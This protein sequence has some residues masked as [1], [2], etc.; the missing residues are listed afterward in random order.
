[1]LYAYLRQ[2]DRKS[3]SRI[4]G[5]LIDGLSIT[6]KDSEP[7]CC[8]NMS[9]PLLFPAGRYKENPISTQAGGLN[10]WYW[11][12]CIPPKGN[13]KSSIQM[14]GLSFRIR[15][16]PRFSQITGTFLDVHFC[17]GGLGRRLKERGSSIHREKRSSKPEQ[18]VADQ[19]LAHD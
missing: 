12:T 14:D 2:A 18:N 16:A 9:E 11:H 6:I 13:T 1:M 19:S 3:E 10:F 8:P 15:S 17:G 4:T 5:C 7:A